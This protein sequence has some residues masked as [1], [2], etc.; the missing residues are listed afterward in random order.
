[1][2]ILIGEKIP[3]LK[4]KRI[5]QE[6]DKKDGLR[7]LVDG[8]WPRGIRKDNS[9]INLWLKDIAPSADLRR[10]FNHEPE[11]WE[12]FCKRY[13]KELH[14]KRELVQRLLDTLKEHD[15]TLLYAAKDERYNNA[16]ALKEYLEAAR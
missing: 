7:I 6:A 2:H 4:L 12:E 13:H 16:A 10:W 9:L 3:N 1:M 5:Y 14:L 8:L 15:V 11:K